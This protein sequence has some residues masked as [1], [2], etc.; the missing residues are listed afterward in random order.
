MWGRNRLRI[1]EIPYLVYNL[2]ACWKKMRGKFLRL[3]IWGSK[4][5][6]G[7]EFVVKE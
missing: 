2:E 1:N 6:K 4:R 3:E 7:E 5:A